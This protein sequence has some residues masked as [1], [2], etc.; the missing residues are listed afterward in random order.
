MNA[1]RLV[2]IVV[3][4]IIAAGAWAFLSAATDS[5]SQSTYSRLAQGE[6][7]G[8]TSGGRASVAQLWGAPQVQHAPQVWTTHI[9]KQSQLNEKGKRVQVDVKKQDFV[10]LSS[11]RV[12]AR[13]ELE[14]RQKGLI[15]YSTYRVRFSGEYSFTN[16][17]AEKKAF[18]VKFAF[19]PGQA[20]YDNVLIRVGGKRVYPGGNLAD[21]VIAPI[22]V[23]PGASTTMKVSYGSQGMDTW[24]YQFATDSAAASVRDFEA[25]IKTNC[26][27]FDFPDN[28][29]SPTHKN[30]RADGWTLTWRFGDLISGKNIGISMPQRLQPGPFASRL[31]KF[32][33]VSLLFFFAVLLIIGTVRDVR[34]HPMHYMF[35]AATFFSFHLLFS[36]LVDHVAPFPSFLVA[37]AVSLLLTISYLRLVV[38]WRFA[39]FQAGLW[40]FVFLV[41][42]TY[43]FF[44]EGYTGLTITIG[45]ILTLA[46]LMQL[47]GRVDW[48]EKLALKPVPPRYPPPTEPTQRPADSPPP[49]PGTKLGP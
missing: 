12:N 2:A 20:A 25:V 15:W 42:F 24:H 19:P 18:F 16:E 11:S 40:Q 21:G 3:I 35:I 30:H 9:E 48:D 31:S 38:N 1:N 23:A 29:L 27:D 5:R 4:Y 7:G 14:P 6:S 34:L 37:S 44:F 43:A 46:L 13:I 49:P 8:Q 26:G 22:E 28:C 32:A 17:Q 47:T 36:Y 10:V 39:V 33:P 45:A 41:L